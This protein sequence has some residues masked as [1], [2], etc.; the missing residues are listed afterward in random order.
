MAKLQRRT[1]LYDTPIKAIRK[2]CFDYWGFIMQSNQIILDQDCSTNERYNS[3]P[4]NKI[5][6][7]KRNQRKGLNYGQV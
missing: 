2:K 1:S 7:R 4:I 6:K 5:S 3:V